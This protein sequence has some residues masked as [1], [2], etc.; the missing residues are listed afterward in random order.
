MR[1][2]RSIVVLALLAQGSAAS[3]MECRVPPHKQLERGLV[4]GSNLVGPGVVNSLV[5]LTWIVGSTVAA[6]FSGKIQLPRFHLARSGFQLNV[7]I[8]SDWYR[9]AT[10]LGI[11]LIEGSDLEAHWAEENFNLHL[12]H[13]SGHAS[14]SALLGPLFLPFTA[15]DYAIHR[16][17]N[18]SVYF[19]RGAGWGGFSRKPE[20]DAWIET[21]ADEIAASGGPRDRLSSRDIRRLIG[22][23]ADGASAPSSSPSELAESTAADGAGRQT[24]PASL[25]SRS[26]ATAAA[27]G[28]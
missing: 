28:P 5:G 17:G 1:T 8:G 10:S 13:E 22:C 25:A 20:D 26:P 15:L 23:R 11:F 18:H 14:Q 19:R 9:H 12:L 27:S 3:A 21:W 16:G 7:T 24:P 4:V 6:P 2:L